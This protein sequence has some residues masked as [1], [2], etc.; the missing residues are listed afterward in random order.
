VDKSPDPY[1]PPAG[2]QSHLSTDDQW[3]ILVGMAHEEQPPE[4]RP[5]SDEQH[6]SNIYWQLSDPM[7]GSTTSI[8]EQDTSESSPTEV[9]DDY[10]PTD[11]ID[12]SITTEELRKSGI[13]ESQYVA[14]APGLDLK[15]TTRLD[16]HESHR[17]AIFVGRG[18]VVV[19]DH[20]HGFHTRHFQLP[21][22]HARASGRAE[23]GHAPIV[24]KI[25]VANI[26]R[27][28]IGWKSLGTHLVLFLDRGDQ[29]VTRL[30]SSVEY[31]YNSSDTWE[32]NVT[33]LEQLCSSAGIAFESH[34]FE[35]AQQFLAAKPE[36]APPLIE[37]QVDHVVEEDAREWGLAFALGLPIAFGLLAV[38]GGALLWLGPVGWAVGS[39]EAVGT[40]VAVV[41][42]VWS[43]SR[44][45]M[46]RSLSRRRLEERP[47]DTG[48]RYE[49]DLRP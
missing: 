3:E 35:T 9:V 40:L 37:F 19:Q 2:E 27:K 22:G 25:V 47:A 48:V 33:A 29:V 5:V 14:L 39:L 42:T 44:W 23:D 7:A 43:H 41:L 10:D 24:A 32:F 4:H 28:A 11:P 30:D 45:R 17:Q 46:R 13:P 34:S 21:A 31:G 36:W 49:E 38:F 16:F 6:G 1:G 8:P 26:R 20:V 12:V 18:E 15:L